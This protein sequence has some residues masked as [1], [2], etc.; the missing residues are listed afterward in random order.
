MKYFRPLP[1]SRLIK[2]N[3]RSKAVCLELEDKTGRKFEA[4]IP[5]TLMKN[6]NP[7]F[8]E[9]VE[10]PWWFLRKKHLLEWFR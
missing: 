10:V 6:P 3:P 2:T 5:K 8:S 4:W 7:E 9:D 1:K